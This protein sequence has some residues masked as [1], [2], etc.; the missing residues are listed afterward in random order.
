MNVRDLVYRSL[1][2]IEKDGKYS[3]L[4]LSAVIEEKELEGKDKSLFTAL[5]YGVTERKVTLDYFICHYTQKSVQRLDLSVVTL[6][7][8]GIYQIV[9]LDKIPDSAAV[10]ETVKLGQRYA[11]RAKGFINGILRSVCREKEALPYPDREKEPLEWMS[12]Y[13]GVQKWICESFC[14]DY[15]TEAEGILESLSRQPT[16]TLRVN[17][18]KTDRQSLLLEYPSLLAPCEWSPYAL[19]MTEAF[20]LSDFEPLHDGRCYVQDEASQI[21]GLVLNPEPGDLILDVCAA[22]GGKSFFAAIS[23]G[24]TGKLISM[25]LHG[26]KLSLIREGAERL[27][28]RNI[29]V[30]ENDSTH[31]LPE[32]IG[33]V[34]KVICDVPCSGLG[35]L[36]KK[37]EIRNKNQKPLDKLNSIQYNILVSSSR[38]LKS[39]GSLVY[40]TCTLRKA[41]NEQIVELFLSEHPDFE[42]VPFSVGKLCSYDGTLTLLPQIHHTDGFFVAKIQRK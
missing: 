21:A 19:R 22:P 33:K 2:A 10:N 1:I 32:Y 13:Y 6:L 35:V 27:G 20:P 34:D 17:T 18:L 41:E 30:I 24:D 7:R 15:P 23:T 9:Y 14:H 37:S 28:I 36:A 38:Y 5:L 8:M 25:D 29:E 12:V 26:S 40:S 42:S 3:N 39:G 11:S 16:V 4:E 31:S